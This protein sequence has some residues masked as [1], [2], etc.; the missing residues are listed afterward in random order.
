M[1]MKESCLFVAEAALRITKLSISI[2]F[3]E[4]LIEQPKATKQLISF[5]RWRAHQDNKQ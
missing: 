5:P 4:W 1:E 3:I 2:Q